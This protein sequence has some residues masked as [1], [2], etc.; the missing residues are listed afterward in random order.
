MDRIEIGRQ[1]VDWINLALVDMLVN[2][3]PNITGKLLNV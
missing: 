2:C 1:I 3:V